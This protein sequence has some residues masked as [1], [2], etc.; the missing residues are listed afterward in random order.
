ML[1]EHLNG[2]DDDYGVNPITRES[3]LSR[4]DRWAMAI[5]AMLVRLAVRA[6]N[7]WFRMVER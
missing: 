6:I 1:T 2:W 3:L 5:A 4:L 7:L